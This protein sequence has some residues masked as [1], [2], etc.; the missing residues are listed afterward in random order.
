MDFARNDLW[1]CVCFYYIA[2]LGVLPQLEAYKNVW[3]VRANLELSLMEYE[4]M[5]LSFK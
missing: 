4:Q 3:S 2:K 1:P 5:Q